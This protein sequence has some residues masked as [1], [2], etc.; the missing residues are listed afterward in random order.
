MSNKKLVP[1]LRNKLANTYKTTK[2]KPRTKGRFPNNYSNLRNSILQNRTIKDAQKRQIIN[3][4]TPMTNKMHSV[5]YS[6][7]YNHDNFVREQIETAERERSEAIKSINDPAYLRVL[8]S[9]F[10]VEAPERTKERRSKRVDKYYPEPI[11]QTHNQAK[12]YG[13]KGQKK[14]I[15]QIRSGKNKC[16]KCKKA[17]THK[18]NLVLVPISRNYVH[19]HHPEQ[20]YYDGIGLPNNINNTY[21][22]GKVPNM[23]KNSHNN[24]NSRQYVIKAPY[25]KFKEENKQKQKKKKKGRFTE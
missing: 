6:H 5:L 20:R 9:L 17:M 14:A 22:R 7:R 3:N 21:Y 15:N 24:Y 11:L 4:S 25:S 23:V 12:T 2:I 18:N 8:G 19:K 13:P 1:R 10:E 16:I